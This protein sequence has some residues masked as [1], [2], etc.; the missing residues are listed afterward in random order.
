MRCPSAEGATTEP[1]DTTAP[2]D[3]TALAAARDRLLFDMRAL[4]TDGVYSS[5]FDKPALLELASHG[6]VSIPASA[7]EPV[8]RRSRDKSAGRAVTQQRQS[9]VA[10]ALEEKE[11]GIVDAMQAVARVVNATDA[12]GLQA[13]TATA[14]AT[15]STTLPPALAEALQTLVSDY[16]ATTSASSTGSAAD[17]VRFAVING[18]SQHLLA[19]AAL[20]WT[21]CAAGHADS[22]MAAGTAVAALRKLRVVTPTELIQH[23]PRMRAMRLAP[24]LATQNGIDPP[25]CIHFTAAARQDSAFVRVL[26][27]H[28]S[29]RVRSHFTLEVL[30]RLPSPD[31]P[32][33]GASRQRSRYGSNTPSRRRRTIISRLIHHG[34]SNRGVSMHACMAWFALLAGALGG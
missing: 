22:A 1:E 34:G 25:P 7:S 12:A 8:S 15:C 27:P 3:A 18:S 17:L 4:A 5:A 30:V 29:L 14:I 16:Q 19:A 13:A 2:P 10:Y 23:L 9:E 32:A 24:M 21:L 6:S 20:L 31:E 33:A 11:Q 28:S 26:Q